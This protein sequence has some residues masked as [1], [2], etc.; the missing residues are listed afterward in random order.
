MEK[1]KRIVSGKITLSILVLTAL[2]YSCNFNKKEAPSIYR[3]MNKK[4]TAVLTLTIDKNRFYGQYEVKY[5]KIGK[6]SGSVRGE[7]IGDSL[8]GIYN[9]ISY[10]GSWKKAPIALLKKNNQL[11]LGKG[12][13]T[14]LLDIPCFVPGIPI[15]YTNPEFVFEKMNKKTEFENATTPK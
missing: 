4:D 15:D 1:A 10:G 12:A 14:T 3:A 9:Y 2:L 11:L 6:D 5:G 13:T 7:I 8:R